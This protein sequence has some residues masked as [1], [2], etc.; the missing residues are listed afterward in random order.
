V[1][2]M[3]SAKNEPKDDDKDT[4]GANAES[5]ESDLA[6]VNESHAEGESQ[7]ADI[8]E[9]QGAAEALESLFISLEGIQGA[10]GLEQGGAMVLSQYASY[11]YGRLGMEGH[12]S[13]PALES[14][15][16]SSSRV[17]AGRIALEDFK[18]Q[19]QRIWKAIADAIKKAIAWVK[20]HWNAI[21][22]AAEKLVKRA[23]ALEERARSTNGVKKAENFENDRLAKAL[24]IENAAP[25]NVVQH[26]NDLKAI[27]SAVVTK[28][29]EVAGK[30]GEEAVAAID[31]LDAK[32]L[33]AILKLV[34]QIQPS[35]KVGNPDSEGL[36]NPG[37]GMELFRSKQLFGGMAVLSRVPAGE[38]DSIEANVKQISM[39]GYS[40]S[41]FSSKVGKEPTNKK[42]VTLSTSDAG[43]LAAVVKDIAEE[44]VAYKKN[45]DALGQ[46]QD[47]LVKAA[48][49]TANS[50]GG[51]ESPEKRKELSA[52]QGLANAANRIITVP[53]TQITKYALNTGTAL[54]NYVELSLKQYGEK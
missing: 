29:A 7:Q 49:K 23:A 14:F 10:G 40:V 44:I 15:G 21:F 31:S 47:K 46:T 18:E 34:A 2:A 28:G 9:A 53:G 6:E 35:E 26:A 41:K 19:I 24:S 32:K 38:S 17:E 13:V 20:N 39:A 48:E 42:L 11:I 12:Q 25:T 52:L 8:D 36:A 33:P 22:G 50:A 27:V 37:E 54:L 43:S 1:A 5:L 3:E 30:V 51:E 16:G 4:L 45:A